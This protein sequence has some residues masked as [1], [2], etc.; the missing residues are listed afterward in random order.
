MRPTKA[1]I[2]RAA[3][4]IK[5]LIPLDRVGPSTSVKN[6][7]LSNWTPKGLAT[8]KWPEDFSASERRVIRAIARIALTSAHY[9]E[10]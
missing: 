9:G 7:A 2:E 6:V 10:G 1:Q 5:F 8:V 4:A 3:D